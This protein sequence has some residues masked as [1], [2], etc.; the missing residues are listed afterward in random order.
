MF[1]N[2]RCFVRFV[3]LY[4]I[5]TFCYTFLEEMSLYAGI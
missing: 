1:A 4:V 3:I 5:K 2:V